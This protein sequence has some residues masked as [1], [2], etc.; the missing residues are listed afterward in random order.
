MPTGTA[1]SWGR[2]PIPSPSPGRGT[3]WCCR[4]GPTSRDFLKKRLRKPH[5][6]SG[7]RAEAGALRVPVPVRVRVSAAVVAPAGAAGLE[8]GDVER[9][10]ELH[11]RRC[12][13][14][15]LDVG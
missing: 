12:P 4:A 11:G 10:V 8:T 7:C 5:E 15:L 1:D 13:V 6:Q 2:S 9:R 3:G 14:G